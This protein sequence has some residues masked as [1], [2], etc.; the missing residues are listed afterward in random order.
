M[1]HSL[2]GM[3]EVISN[4]GKALVRKGHQVVIITSKKQG[5]PE[6]I[7]INGIKTYLVDAYGEKYSKISG[8]KY[9]LNLLNF[10]IKINL[11]W[12]IV[13]VSLDIILIKNQDISVPIVTSIYGT[14][15]DEIKTS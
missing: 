10:I 4:L 13:I 11:I 15:W 6:E 8:L 3:Q 9:M 14:S 12:L 5:S 1:D 7:V 2:W